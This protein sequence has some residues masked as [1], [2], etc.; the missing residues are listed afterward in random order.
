MLIRHSIAGA[1]A[2]VLVA[3][4]AFV[5]WKRRRGRTSS[6]V[7]SYLTHGLVL[8]LIVLSISSSQT[9]NQWMKLMSQL[10]SQLE[11]SAGQRMMAAQA[12]SS[13]SSMLIMSKFS[14]LDT[15]ALKSRYTARPRTFPRSLTRNSQSHCLLARAHTSSILFQ[16]LL[17]VFTKQQTFIAC[18]SLEEAF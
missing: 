13:T 8:V 10:K 18:M 16:P 3:V 5:V 1:A 4:L 15:K 6:A 17:P 7:H 12:W 2:A 9:Q 14:N 11:K